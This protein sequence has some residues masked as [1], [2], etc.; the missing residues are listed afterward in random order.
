MKRERIAAVVALAAVLAAPAAAQAAPQYPSGQHRLQ[1]ERMHRHALYHP[2]YRYEYQPTYH[3]ETG[4]EDGVI[5]DDVTGVN[6]FGAPPY[7]WGYD[8]RQFPY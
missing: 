4:D 3:H 7:P 8:G 2:A 6:P 1:Q 5:A